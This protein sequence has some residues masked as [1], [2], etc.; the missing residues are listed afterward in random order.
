MIAALQWVRDNVSAFGGDPANVTLFGESGGAFCIAALMTSPL[1]AGLFRRAIC[2]SGHVYVSRDLALMQRLMRRVAKRLRVTPDR[3]GFLSKPAEALLPAQDWAMRPS[4]FWDHRDAEGRDPSFGITRFLPVHGDDVLPA[5]AIQALGAG[6]GREVDLLIGTNTD[7]GNLFFA[8]GG[9]LKKI[10]RWVANYF[11]G[12]AIPRSREAL[13]AYGLDAPGAR[14]GE[15]LS[16]ALTDLMFRWM[17]RRTAELHGGRT[18]V[19]EFDWRSPALDGA[20][21]AAHAVELPFVFNTLPAASGDNGLLGANPPQALADSI[22]KLWIRFATDG[23]LPWPTYEPDTRLVYSLT[24]ETAEPEAVMP[25]A[26][27]LP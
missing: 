11:L 22:H 7:E 6:A 19:Y 15:V 23:D 14:A 16:R 17:A 4:L 27:F 10:N 21:G 20:L 13:R 5:P 2:Q 8:P 25:A 12:R 1:A 9:G 24:R 26:A 3:A 18:W